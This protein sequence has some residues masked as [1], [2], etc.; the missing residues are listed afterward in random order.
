[1]NFSSFFE[2]KWGGD[3]KNQDREFWEKYKSGRKK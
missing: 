1:M 2:R 3:W